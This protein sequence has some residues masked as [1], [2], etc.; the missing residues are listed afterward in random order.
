MELGAQIKLIDL[1]IAK[2]MQSE[3]ALTVGGAFLGKLRYC[4]PEQLASGSST[5]PSTAEATCSR[6]ASCSPRC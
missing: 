2:V 4:S 5:P 6:S 3:E 1:G